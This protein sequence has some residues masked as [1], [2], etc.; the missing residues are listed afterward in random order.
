MR[1]AAFGR[2]LIKLK[3]A[4]IPEVMSLKLESYDFGIEN[5]SEFTMNSFFYT[6]SSNEQQEYTAKTIYQKFFVKI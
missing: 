1:A 4:L 2:L 6:V 5:L 3:I